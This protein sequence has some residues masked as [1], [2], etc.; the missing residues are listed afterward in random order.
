VEPLTQEWENTVPLNV[1][2][3]CL[4]RKTLFFNGIGIEE[5]SEHEP[6]GC[7]LK[8]HTLQVNN[9]STATVLNKLKT[10]SVK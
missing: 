10:F 8:G 4:K 5:C 9:T 2:P 6:V 3:F 7:N 1:Y